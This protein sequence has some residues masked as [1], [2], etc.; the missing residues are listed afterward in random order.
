M[1]KQIT[2]VEDLTPDPHNANRGTARG[3]ALLDTSLRTYGAGRSILADK[4]GT[5]IAGNKTLEAAAELGLTIREVHT[6]GDELV[7]VV[8]DD[9]SLATDKAARELAYADNRVGQIDLDFDPVV[10]AADLE[11][12]VDLSKF[13]FEPELA[14]VLEQAG[15]ELIEQAN[16]A[17][18]APE[19]ARQTLTERFGVPPFTVLDTRQ[20]Y[21]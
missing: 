2:A 1:P 17:A 12:G 16:G 4:D 7:V 14:A 8:R 5:V 11:A 18:P 19:Q 9:L 20:G 15:T 6:T 21:W 10:L 3:R 13:W